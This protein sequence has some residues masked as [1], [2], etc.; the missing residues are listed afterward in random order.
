MTHGQVVDRA[1]AGDELRQVF[2]GLAQPVV[3]VTGRSLSG[4]PVGMTV[5]SL[6]S[7]SLTPPLL[8]FCPATTSR[9]W[10]TAREWGAFAVNVLGREHTGLAARFAGPGDRFAGLRTAAADD[11]V[12][13]LADALTALHCAVHDEYPAGDHTVVLGRVRA[14][15]RFR[16]GTGLDTVSMRGGPVP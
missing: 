10:T 2:R 5:S 11:G 7:V 15:R 14:V 6:V 8:L 3:V 16:D 13:L 12:P 4:E 1:V 9:T